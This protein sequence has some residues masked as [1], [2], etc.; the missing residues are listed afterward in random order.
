M[1]VVTLV[2]TS[3]PRLSKEAPYRDVGSGV[4]RLQYE[5][6]QNRI[7]HGE[8]EDATSEIGV[9]LDAH[10][11]RR[12]YLTRHPEVWQLQIVTDGNALSTLPQPRVFR[13]RPPNRVP[14]NFRCCHRHHRNKPFSLL[15]LF[16]VS[17]TKKKEEEAIIVYF[18]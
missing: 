10:H 18:L 6:L 11:E 1:T 17:L 3:H 12:F 16:I 15:P 9:P 14:D 8:H 4:A 2:V 5:A 13:F 7:A